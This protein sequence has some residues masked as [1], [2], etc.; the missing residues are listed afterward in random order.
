MADKLSD[1]AQK[2]LRLWEDGCLAHHDDFCRGYTERYR[3]YKALLDPKSI[4]AMQDWQ[5]KLTPAFARHIVETQMAG[6]VDSRLAFKVRPAPRFFDPGEYER[7]KQGAKAHE[8]LHHQQMKRDRFHEKLRPFA[9]QDAIAGLTVAKNYYQSEKRVQRELVFEPDEDILDRFG[10][11]VLRPREVER[12]QVDTGPTTEIV[13]VYDFF[14][15][16]AAVELQRSPVIAHRVWMHFAEL[17]RLEA[18]GVYRNVDRLKESRNQ[19]SYQDTEVDLDSRSR[20]K[21]MI[22]VLEIW[23]QEPDGWHV[24]VL[25][26]RN[27]E[28]KA[29][30]PN[31]FNHGEAPFVACSTR[32]DLFRIAGTSQ[33]EAIAPLQKAHWDI[34]N[35]TRE[36]LAYQNN[37]IV[38]VNTQ[39][40]DDIDALVHEPGAR[41]PI[42]G[43][44]D[45]ALQQFETSPITTEMSLPHLARLEQMMQ[46]FGGSQP[47]TSTSEAQSIGAG[48]ATEAALVTN[49]AQRATIALKEQ[50]NYAY[51]R[52]GQ[53]RTEL[54]K[55]FIRTPQIVQQIG[56]DN[57][58]E[59]TEIAPYLLQG[60][61]L[62]DITPMNES[63][64]RAER[65]AEANSLA[66]VLM[67]WV[68]IQ[69]QLAQAGAATPINTD[70]LLEYLIEQHDMGDPKRF[71]S[72]RPQP[73]VQQQP[74]Q[75]GAPDGGQ[76]LGVTGTG[77][78][79]PAVSPSAQASVS[80]ET[81]L[82]R[83]G[84]RSGGPMNV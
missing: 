8:I 30:R 11:E 29:D 79:D 10:V 48:T 12:V 81:M 84:A 56:L 24:V 18:K 69:A 72:S 20:T 25:G 76:P 27:V 1:A 5:V 4:S 22:E 50:L 62:F 66:Q 37:F 44:L 23:R 16:E 70:A 53:Q 82:A 49:L 65:K 63:L 36:N 21:D 40:V 74:Q 28:L 15:H 59:Q 43:P 7:L 26:N 41:W 78:I 19:E 58:Y 3:A 39:M 38:A 17:K 33:V 46:N 80:P 42:D 77:S 47:F 9:L 14:W 54:N 32:P 60:D 83:E 61:Y 75:Q 31:P 51:E 55:Q 71:F 68:A 64:M 45:Q 35:A 34:D 73:P 13:N 6:L 67:P 57:E 2:S 52:I